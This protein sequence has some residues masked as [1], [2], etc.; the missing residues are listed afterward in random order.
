MFDELPP[1]YD[2]NLDMWSNYI[3]KY[4]S[5]TKDTYAWRKENVV[6][7]ETEGE[8]AYELDGHDNTSWC[9]S[10]VLQYEKQFLGGRDV[11]MLYV[12]FRVY[13]KTD[14]QYR[15]DERGTFDGWSNRFDEW[16]PAYSPRI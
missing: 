15:K 16:I 4:E 8:K 9:K 11:D 12:G 5:K 1:H 2:G 10:T 14:N 7:C 3:A 13:R 6:N